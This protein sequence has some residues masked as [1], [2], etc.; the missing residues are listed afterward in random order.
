MEMKTYEM[1]YKRDSRN[2]MRRTF[3]YTICTASG[4]RVC[5]FGSMSTL[6]L[7]ILSGRG[8]EFKPDVA[9]SIIC[10]ILHKYIFSLLFIHRIHPQ[11]RTHI[12]ILHFPRKFSRLFSTQN[13][14]NHNNKQFIKNKILMRFLRCYNIILSIFLLLKAES[15]VCKNISY[16]FTLILKISN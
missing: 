16:T 13:N 11:A 3:L 8:L 15:A 14:N 7:C 6:M 1:I 9:M 10:T 4:C 2:N 12:R 5:G